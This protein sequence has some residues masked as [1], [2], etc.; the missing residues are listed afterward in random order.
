[1]NL[2]EEKLEKLLVETNNLSL[3]ADVRGELMKCLPKVLADDHMSLTRTRSVDVWAGAYYVDEEYILYTFTFGDENVEVKTS[4]C[5]DEVI[6]GVEKNAVE[7]FSTLGLLNIITAGAVL[8]PFKD[9]ELNSCEIKLGYDLY[10]ATPEMLKI[11]V[12]AP[13][14]TSCPLQYFYALRNASN[15]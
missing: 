4:P 8:T 14:T 2:V 7:L 6:E 12:S 3:Q 13:F 1:M 11:W 9:H 15:K 5:A 10:R